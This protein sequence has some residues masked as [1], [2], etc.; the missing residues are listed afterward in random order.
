MTARRERPQAHV[1]GRWS[2]EAGRSDA[3]F[4]REE[5]QRRRWRGCI[6]LRKR[7]RD[8]GRGAGGEGRGSR[9]NERKRLPIVGFS[10]IE[11]QL[12]SP[13]GH[14]R[15]LSDEA[16]EASN[17][18]RASVSRRQGCGRVR[19]LLCMAAGGGSVIVLRLLFR[20]C[21]TRDFQRM[22]AAGG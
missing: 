19:R 17:R 18:N 5:L 13:A 9:S 11:A 16:A 2:G 20:A 12:E 15:G 8:T 1:R 4:R 7:L 21:L 22:R 10:S 6:G 14:V 3:A